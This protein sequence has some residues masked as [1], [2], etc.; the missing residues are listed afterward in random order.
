MEEE[1]TIL[2]CPNCKTPIPA[3]V[4]LSDPTAEPPEPGTQI[5]CPNCGYEGFPEEVTEEE[6]KKIKEGG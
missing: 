1:K 5:K 3:E 4:D 2:I 6:F